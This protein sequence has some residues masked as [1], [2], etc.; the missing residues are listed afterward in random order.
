MPASLSR[1]AQPA[2]AGQGSCKRWLHNCH[3]RHHRCM[4]PLALAALTVERPLSC[5]HAMTKLMMHHDALRLQG[6][7]SSLNLAILNP[8]SALHSCCVTRL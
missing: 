6:P 2:P 5:Q 7:A 1:A 8:T 3:L 4:Q